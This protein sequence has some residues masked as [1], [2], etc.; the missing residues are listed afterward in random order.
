MDDSEVKEFIKYTV[1]VTLKELNKK[2]MLTVFN[3][4]SYAKTEKLLYLYPYLGTKNKQRKKIDEALNKVKD[5]KYFKIIKMRYFKVM[6]YE[7]IANCL[8]VKKQTICKHNKKLVNKLSMVLFANEIA[9]EI[10]EN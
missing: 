6:T 8:E 3:F 7:E 1:D 2:N 5:E 10:F 4:N 9:K